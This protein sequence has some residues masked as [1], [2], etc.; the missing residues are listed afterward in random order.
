MLGCMFQ[1]TCHR[2]GR[3]LKQL[4]FN[5]C[6]VEATLGQALCGLATAA[7]FTRGSPTMWFKFGC[8]SCEYRIRGRMGAV[9]GRH[10]FSPSGEVG[11]GRVLQLGLPRLARE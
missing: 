2:I 4:V 11:N 6:R 8:Q 5:E 10:F 9:A 3:G 7:L 1:A